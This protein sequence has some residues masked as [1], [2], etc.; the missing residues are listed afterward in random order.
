MLEP[1]DIL[2][3]YIGKGDTNQILI[4]KSKENKVDLIDLSEMKEEYR[5]I[6]ILISE[7]ITLNEISK[8]LNIDLTDLYQRIFLMELEGLIENKDNKY[9]I[10]KGVRQ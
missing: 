10:K 8:T 2:N 1:E 5:D 6:Y 7:D 3:K 9:K 4:Q